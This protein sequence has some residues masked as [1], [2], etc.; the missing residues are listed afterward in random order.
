M[1]MRSQA[2]T[3]S[4]RAHGDGGL[5]R[6]LCPGD[7]DVRLRVINDQ[8]YAARL[9]LDA[10]ADVGAFRPVHA[11]STALHQ[12]VLTDDVALIDLLLEHGA[13][14]DVRDRVWNGTPLDWAIHERR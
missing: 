12:A 8:P 7:P 14:M 2:R 13:P 3:R 4:A 5:P 10:G 1:R 11:H 9:A 6:A